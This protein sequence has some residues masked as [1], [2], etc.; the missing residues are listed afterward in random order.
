MK[1]MFRRKKDIRVG[2][3]GYGGAYNMGRKHLNHLK[4][5]GM[6]PVAVCDTDP[7]RLE[8]ARSDFVGIETFRSVDRMLK[9]SDL[10]L[11]VVVTPH[12]THTRIALKCLE[13]GR[14]VICEK[15]FAITVDQCDA[16]IASA[17][18]RGLVVSTYHNRHWDGCV[19][20]AVDQ[21]LKRKVIGDVVSAEIRFG[22]YEMPSSTW[23]GSKSI[24]GGLTYDWGVH[25]LEYA[26]QI[27]D[28][29]M[30]EVSGFSSTGVWSSKS[31]WKEDVIEDVVFGVVRFA[32][33]KWLTLSMSQIE[34]NQKKGFL[35][36]SGT[37]GSYVM[38]H[39]SYE[40]IQPRSDGRILRTEGANRPTQNCFYKNIADH[41][42]RGTRLAIT[43]EWARRPIQI[44]DMVNQSAKSGKSIRLRYR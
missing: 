4:A 26:L 15:P 28:A 23:R 42:T 29:D 3:V 31:R 19:V 40:I 37:K 44:L 7:E 22:G 9:R 8:L 14:H 27:L 11:V 24:S 36:V 6:T 38:D 41:L 34:A 16:M 17:R 2:V 21:I 10:N 43:P 1:G 5:E 39:L 13:A 33:Q 18:K 30:L 12:N 35:E 25:F 20:E 32:G